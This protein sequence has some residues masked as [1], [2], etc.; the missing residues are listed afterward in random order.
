M[1]C[2][3]PFLE[4]AYPLGALLSKRLTVCDNL[5]NRN[6][7]VRAVACLSEF[8]LSLGARTAF[9]AAVKASDFWEVFLS[10]SLLAV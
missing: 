6:G 2:L 8:G 3:P 5:S 10:V 9:E 7:S 1:T 4:D